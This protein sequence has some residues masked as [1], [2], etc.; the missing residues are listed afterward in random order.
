MAHP[1]GVPI[2][3]RVPSYAFREATPRSVEVSLRAWRRL[4]RQA[5]HRDTALACPRSTNSEPRLASDCYRGRV[6]G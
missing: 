3:V 6:E 1:A 2:E 4:R 5:R